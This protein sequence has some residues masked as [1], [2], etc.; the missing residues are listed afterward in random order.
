[1]SKIKMTHEGQ[2]CRKCS[3]P[4]VM[5]AHDGPSGNDQSYWF[6]YWFHCPSCKTDYMVDAAKVWITPQDEMVSLSTDKQVRRGQL[7]KL[8]EEC[9]GLN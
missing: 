5:R 6:R 1:M 9:D 4:V 8:L 3:T 7:L 2:P